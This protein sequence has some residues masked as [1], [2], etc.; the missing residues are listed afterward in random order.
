MPLL[1][2]A[3][4]AIGLNA[5][6]CHW[7]DSKVDWSRFDA[8]LL[9]SPWNYVEHL[10]EFLLWCELVS[11]SSQLF[12]PLPAVRW[13][14]NKRYLADL[15]DRDVPI[16]PTGFVERHED[17]RTAYETFLAAHPQAKEVVIKPTVGAYS[18]DVQRYCRAMKTAAVAYIEQ[19]LGRGQRVI[20]Q[21]Y[22]A[23][24][25]RAGETNLTFFN[26]IYSHAIRKCPM[27][28]PDGTVRVPTQ[29]LR[30]ARTA[31]ETERAV[32]AAALRAAAEHLR[33]DRPLLYGRVDLIRDDEG[34]PVVLELEICEPSLNLPFAQDSAM[35]FA[36][37]IVQR[38]DH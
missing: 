14:L 30:Q 17:L 37:A 7:E 25:D 35:R 32:A 13:G 15:A 36:A 28:M 11:A 10:P 5:K 31:D 16:V 4:N 26:G 33:L 18:K 3:C 2:N 22:L 19:L 12:N 38:L 6:V 21:P 20:L 27:L 24:I 34:Q 8:V 29:D 1:L 9:R 23:A